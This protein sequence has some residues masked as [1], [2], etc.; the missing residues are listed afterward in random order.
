ML[1]IPAGQTGAWQPLDYRIFGSL[2]ARARAEFDQHHV[3]VLEG[4]EECINWERAISVLLDCWEQVSNEEIIESWANL[5]Q[6]ARNWIPS[7]SD[8]FDSTVSS[9]SSD[10]SNSPTTNQTNKADN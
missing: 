8:P 9:D 5:D 1:Y 6:Q 4:N 7:S 10:E 3:S 2:K